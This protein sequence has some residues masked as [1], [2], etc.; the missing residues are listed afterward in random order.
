MPEPEMLIIESDHP[1]YK[2]WATDYMHYFEEINI[3]GA[4]AYHV[5][6]DSKSSITE[7]NSNNGYKD[8]LTFFRD[9]HYNTYWGSPVYS[10]NSE[11]GPWNPDYNLT[12]YDSTFIIYFLS[13]WG[14]A[15]D[16]GYKL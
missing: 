14:D 1:Y 15:S 7:R 13:Y 2:Q 16:Y 11:H 6:F 3:P 4:V 12:I 5:R 9:S 10:G 8:Q